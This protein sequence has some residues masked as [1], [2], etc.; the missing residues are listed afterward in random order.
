MMA[1]NFFCVRTAIIEEDD[2]EK[3]LHCILTKLFFFLKC[4]SAIGMC[5]SER[6]SD[7]EK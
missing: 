5:L 4:F 2:I 1:H 6:S 3:E 7:S